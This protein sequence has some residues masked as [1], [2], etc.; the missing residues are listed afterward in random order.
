MISQSL[1]AKAFRPFFLLAALFAVIAMIVWSLVLAGSGPPLGAQ[2]HGHEMIFGYGG[3]VIA[4]FILT[5]ASNWT[6]RRAVSGLPLVLLVLAWLAARIVVVMPDLPALFKAVVCASFFA[7]LALAAGWSVILARSRR[8]YAVVGLLAAFSALELLFWLVPSFR[9]RVLHS[10]LMLILVLIAI[11]GGRVIPLFTRNATPGLHTRPG[12]QWRDFIAVAI[13]VA[14]SVLALCPNCSR[15]LYG[16]IAALGA[17]THLLRMQGWGTARTLT[18]PI[19]WVLH[20]AYL[21]L[22]AGL[23]LLA[24]RDF[25]VPIPALVPLHVLAVGALG[26]M[27]LGMMTRVSLGHTGRIVAADRKT[28]L[29]Y[30]LLLL[31]VV[32]RAAGPFLCSAS[33]RAAMLLAASLWIAAFAIFLASYVR[34]LVTRRVDDKPA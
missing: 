24:A 14:L 8:N 15:A 7:S 5:A 10:A 9:V 3:A 29:A 26:L 21:C 28:T 1:L 16:A 4:G 22:P 31:A 2:W 34:V 13:L 27:T 19:L 32:V 25:N 33:Y 17:L 20:L 18:R 12:R 23:A 6:G 11:I 30:V